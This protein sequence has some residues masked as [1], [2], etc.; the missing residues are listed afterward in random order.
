MKLISICWADFCRGESGVIPGEGLNRATSGNDHSWERTELPSKREHWFSPENAVLLVM[1]IQILN[2]DGKD[3][4]MIYCDHCHLEIDNA[5]M[6]NAIWLSDAS[7]EEG[8][9]FDV[10]HVHKECD[11]E[12]QRSH[13]APDGRLWHWQGLNHH[14]VMLLANCE[15]DEGKGRQTRDRL[16]QLGP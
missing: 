3:Y 14:F 4:P 11:D 2:K 16:D 15:Y 5:E 8:F 10:G 1:A 12:F 6:G 9:R 13:P 7:K